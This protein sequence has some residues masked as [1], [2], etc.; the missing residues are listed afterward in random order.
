M[1]IREE[2]IENIKH[3]KDINDLTHVLKDENNQLGDEPAEN[4]V[5]ALVS[6]NDDM[7]TLALNTF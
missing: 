4:C 5:E 7:K 6:F 3:F 2:A 1:Q